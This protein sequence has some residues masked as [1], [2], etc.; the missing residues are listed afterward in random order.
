V[1]RYSTSGFERIAAPNV[2]FGSV[3]WAL[4]PL[5]TLGWGAGS[6]FFDAADRARSR[7]L[8]VVATCW[9][10]VG[11]P[12]LLL[13]NAGGSGSDWWGTV[14]GPLAVGLMGVGTVHAFAIPRRIAEAPDPAGSS[15]RGF[16]AVQQA[17]IDATRQRIAY[18]STAR[19]IVDGDP[20]LAHELGIGR[21]DLHREFPDGGM[22]DVNHVGA[23]WP[24]HVP[25]IDAELVEQIVSTRRS[26]GGYTDLTDLSLTLGVVPRCSTSPREFV[27]FLRLPAA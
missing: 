11:M 2:P 9:L 22:V 10:I 7:R 12:S 3:I 16:G 14:G 20:V 21:P 23:R 18:R 1:N 6:S 5:V 8:T 24:A 13:V 4:V 19:L 27:V 15:R 25:G 26:V 17:A